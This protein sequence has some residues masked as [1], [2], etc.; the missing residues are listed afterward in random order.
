MDVKFKDL[1]NGDMFECYGDIFINYNYSK[2]CR[3]IKIDEDTAQEIDGC[4]FLVDHS[5]Y[6]YKVDSNERI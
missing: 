3:C 6:V 1:E 4:N 5:D 2:I